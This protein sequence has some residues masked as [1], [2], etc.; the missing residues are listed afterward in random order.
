MEQ[1]LR[2][3]DGERISDTVQR[4]YAAFAASAACAL[5]PA[6]GDMWHWLERAMNFCLLY[7]GPQGET[8]LSLRLELQQQR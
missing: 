6:A 5:D 7:E 2:L 4:C 3:L 1:I 8:Y